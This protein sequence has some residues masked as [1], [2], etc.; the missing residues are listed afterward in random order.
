MTAQKPDEA[1]SSPSAIAVPATGGEEQKH[2]MQL[3][4]ETADSAI[5]MISGVEPVKPPASMVDIAP[6]AVT[7][8]NPFEEDA[9][10][11]SASAELVPELP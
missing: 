10:S 9:K 11:R 1:K 7:E 8:S 3:R 4:I 2:P 6:S 5:S